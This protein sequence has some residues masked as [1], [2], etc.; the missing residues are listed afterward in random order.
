MY[1][2]HSR[3]RTH[4]QFLVTKSKNYNVELFLIS[5]LLN[6]LLA[7]L[8]KCEPLK[9]I[10][11]VFNFLSIAKALRHLGHNRNTEYIKRIY[12]GMTQSVT[13]LLKTF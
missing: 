4:E 13:Q 12:I 11:C 1:Q 9:G 8:G 10:Y 2:T 5:K 6:H 3:M 7:H